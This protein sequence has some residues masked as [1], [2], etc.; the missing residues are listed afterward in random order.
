MLT[1][2]P[3]TWRRPCCKCRL[4]MTGRRTTLFPITLSYVGRGLLGVRRQDVA[5]GQLGH[6]VLGTGHQT[7]RRA[8]RFESSGHHSGS[9]FLHWA[10]SRAPLLPT[11]RFVMLNEGRDIGSDDEGATA[12]PFLP[13]TG[14]SLSRVE[15]SLHTLEPR[16]RSR[17]SELE[18]LWRRSRVRSC[19][20]ALPA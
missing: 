6:A 10:G 11:R 3:S 16:E 8:R 5:P 20:Q 14:R 17:D 19:R 12:G 9:P 1:T 7:L 4:D 13:R 18:F 15:I 2:L